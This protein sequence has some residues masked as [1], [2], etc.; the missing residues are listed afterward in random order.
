MWKDRL[1]QRKGEG[2]PRG[3]INFM[4]KRLCFQA[5][6]NYFECI[7]SQHTDDPNK[8]KCIDQL[9]AY[10]T[11]CTNDFIYRRKQRFLK[12]EMDKKIWTQDRL[13]LI[14]AKRNF[15]NYSNY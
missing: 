4:D 8:F 14:N 5:H 15:S 3:S 13:D 7:E 12:N 6:D 9:Y 10:Q 11:Y 1:Q 2:A